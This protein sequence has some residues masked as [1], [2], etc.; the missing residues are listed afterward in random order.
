M[1]ATSSLD[2]AVR[3]GQRVAVLAPLPGRVEAMV[4]VVP[5]REAGARRSILTALSPLP[6]AA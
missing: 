6:Q 5:G 3:V 2:E 1:L 4:E